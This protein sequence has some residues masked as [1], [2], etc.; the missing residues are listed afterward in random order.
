MATVESGPEGVEESVPA[1][2]KLGSELG[3]LTN[4]EGLGKTLLWGLIFKSS[5]REKG[6]L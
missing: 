3:S 2:G 5:L 1:V 6:C 4:G